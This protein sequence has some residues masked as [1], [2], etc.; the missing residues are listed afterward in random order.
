MGIKTV[1]GLLRNLGPP[2]T[3]ISLSVVVSPLEFPVIH[4]FRVDTEYPVNSKLRLRVNIF[5]T[6]YG[7]EVEFIRATTG[8][9]NIK[10]EVIC[11]D[12]I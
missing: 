2:S 9:T 5:N 4:C 3:E 10:F 7:I 6:P 11:V 8:I 12:K 1:H